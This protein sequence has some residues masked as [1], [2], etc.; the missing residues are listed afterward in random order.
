MSGE[1]EVPKKSD[2]VEKVIRGRWRTVLNPYITALNA[3]GNEVFGNN[4]RTLVAVQEANRVGERIQ[5]SQVFAASYDPT[6]GEDPLEKMLWGTTFGPVMPPLRIFLF[7]GADPAKPRAVVGQVEN[8]KLQ[9]VDASQSLEG[10][11][12]PPLKDSA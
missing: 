5:H 6:L 10:R 1:E 7:G 9:W 2:S 4:R 3:K 11:V 8:E 12:I